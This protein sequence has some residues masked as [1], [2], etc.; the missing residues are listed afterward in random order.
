MLA[1]TIKNKKSWKKTAILAVGFFVAVFLF[2]NLAPVLAQIVVPENLEP[3]PDTFGLEVVGGSIGL[4]NMDI[5]LIVARII[6]AVLG[7]LGIISIVIMMY[8]G[9]LIMTAGGNE[10]KITQGKRTMINATIG[11]AIILSSF[12]IVQFV[13]N[14]LTGQLN[15]GTA[16]DYVK[17]TTIN[18]YAGSGALGLIV[19]DHYPARDQI[20][21]K[22]NTSIMVTFAEAVDPSSLIENTNDTCYGQ[23]DLIVVCDETN[24]VPV[25][26]DCLDVDYT[27]NFYE[28]NCDQLITDSV[29]IYKSDDESKTLVSAAAMTTYDGEGNA[30]TFVFKPLEPIGSDL[31]DIW[32]TVDLR[33]G[34][35]K[36]NLLNGES[37][38]IFPGFSLSNYLWEFQT[39]VNFDFEPPVVENTNPDEDEDDVPRNRLLQVTF[40]EPMNPITVQGI[41][42][43]SSAFDNI[44]VNRPEMDTED[45]IV[46]SGEWKITNGYRTIEFT[47]DQ[48]CGYNSCGELMYCLSVDCS[49]ATPNCINYYE[50]VIRT[51]LSIVGGIKFAAFPLSG[52]TDAADNA[53]NG[54]K[55]DIFDPRPDKGREIDGG[56]SLK[57]IGEDEKKPDNYLWSYHVINEIDRSAP[58]VESVEPPLDQ[59]A[60][61]E[62]TPI[63][64]N[65]SKEMILSS[66]DN[67]KLVEHPDDSL[68]GDG[69]VIE[70]KDRDYYTDGGSCFSVGDGGEADKRCLPHMAYW[71]ISRIINQKTRTELGHRDLGPNDY[72]FYYFVEIPSAVKD[73]NQNCIYP[74]YGP[75]TDEGG[76]SPVCEVLYDN[77][78]NITTSTNCVEVNFNADTDTG[79]IQTT[80]DPAS[81]LQPNT[82]ACIEF[83]K[84]ISI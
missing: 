46:I 74:G 29:E 3:S 75:D 32:Y 71:D 84:D 81:K 17:K 28:E 55:D 62:K 45:K 5:R 6:R 40:N 82:G 69:N 31:E 58:F 12:A 41:F 20:G 2:L 44:I 80:D 9:Y 8:A 83:L 26:G 7:L 65:F 53:L 42:S 30:Y 67:L 14:M 21:V 35:L 24:N 56:F 37:V 76:S 16:P 79:C 49:E 78:G 47:P 10:D 36:K 61:A 27:G 51:A 64:I 34:I 50:T 1:W 15:N 38:S 66:L 43:T 39:D 13:L 70:D 18:T 33:P 25:Y 54:N 22:R 63:I 60:V 4:S 11:L 73:E 19:K 57:L 48:E 52:V 68:D 77:D 59:G 23:D 72:D